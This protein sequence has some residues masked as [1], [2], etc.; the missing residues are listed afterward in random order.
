MLSGLAVWLVGLQTLVGSG[1][2]AVALVQ[3]PAPAEPVRVRRIAG[4]LRIHENFASK[5]LGNQRTVAV[6]LPPQYAREPNQRFPVLMLQDGQNLVDGTRSFIPNQEWRVDEIAQALMEAG[7]VEP[8]IIV[9]VDNAGMARAD[10][11][12]PTSRVMVEGRAP[13]GGK[14]N[15]YA[16]F[17]FGE[18]LPFV[19]RTYRT[20]TAAS[21]TGLG[22]SSF[23]G[24]STLVIGLRN[25]GRV[26]RLA[27]VSPSV[28]WDDR[29]VVREVAALKRRSDT[30]IWLDI[31]GAES[32]RAVEDTL[33][34]RD[35]LV[36]KGWRLRRDLACVVE[37]HA[38]HNEPAW[39]R[40]FGEMLLFLYPARR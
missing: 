23:G 34:L 21:V 19:H 31:G 4:D 7:L 38:E 40:R 17:L 13:I 2:G 33:A 5:G 18:V 26:G 16:K 27:V 24:I 39:A 30:R 32:T 10:E 14:V 15:D 9:G 6:W 37:P 3:P 8:V 20:Q 25:P 28:W 11:Y 35:A 1:A 29:V 36:A 22:G 12:L